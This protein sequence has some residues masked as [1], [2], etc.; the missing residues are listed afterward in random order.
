MK[1]YTRDKEDRNILRKMKANWI[2]HILHRN[3]LL[4]HVIERKIEETREM[5]GRRGGRI[6][7]LLEE[8][9][10]EE[11]HWKLK[12]EALARTLGRTHFGRVYGRVVRQT[13]D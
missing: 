5:M 9:K 12:E 1:Y 7:Q 4:N 11:G 8:L 3:C 10:E 6:K 13:T 2:G